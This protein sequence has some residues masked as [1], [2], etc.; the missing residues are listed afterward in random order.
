MDKKLYDP[1]RELPPAESAER[2]LAHL[3][4]WLAELAGRDDVA[5]TPETE[6]AA[7]RADFGDP[8]A[9]ADALLPQLHDK[10][11]LWLMPEE[12]VGL[13]SLRELAR[14][15]ASEV[16]VPMPAAGYT[17]P[18]AGGSW[19][20]R[21][22]AP[23][24]HR[25]RKGHSAVF[26]LGPPRSGT[27]LLRAMLT[28]HPALF[29]PPELNLLPF[30]TL[31][32]KRQEL[33]AAGING[34]ETGLTQAFMHLHRCAYDA[35]DVHARALEASG[36]PMAEVYQR[37]QEHASGRLIVDKSPLYQAHVGWLQRAEQMFDAPKYLFLTRH[38]FP[39]MESMVRHRFNRWLK[40]WFG[41]WDDNP[42]L[43]AEKLW[44]VYTQNALTFLADIPAERQHRVS[45][46]ALVTDPGPVMR[47]VC[48]FLGVA[49]DA[50]VLDPYAGE[51]MLDGVGDPG[52]KGRGRIAAELAC[53]KPP[54]FSHPMHRLTRQVAE[55]LGY[56]L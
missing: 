23:Y 32:A 52:L 7:L 22:P 55:Q 2:L 29:S 13:K 3:P 50:S 41:F 1:L 34:F 51:R 35:A 44:A 40:N 48:R 28:G 6:L 18:L 37:L 8:K 26:L 31:A 45:Y 15:I 43:F 54:R 27:T 49:F 20:F 21:T 16:H 10:L 14:Y 33:A 46:E 17:D 30:D 36:A 56:N 11:G 53:V 47:E 38:P 39:V 9:L 25:S 19:V 12:L 5:I 4:A 24:S 42:W